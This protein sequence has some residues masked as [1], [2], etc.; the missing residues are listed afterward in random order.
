M[1]MPFADDLVIGAQTFRMQGLPID[2]GI[3]WFLAFAGLSV[4]GIM[5]GGWASNNKYSLLGSMRSAAQVISY[6]AAMG[7]FGL[8]SYHLWFC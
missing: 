4:Y 2:L 6:E 7:L 5:I 1:V 3:L 8:Y